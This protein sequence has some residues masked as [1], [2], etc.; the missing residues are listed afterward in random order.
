MKQSKAKIVGIIVLVVAIL[1]A[2]TGIYF[3]GILQSWGSGDEQFLVETEHY[4]IEAKIDGK[5][6]STEELD[7]W[8]IDRIRKVE[9]TLD[10]DAMEETNAQVMLAVLTEEKLAMSYDEMVGKLESKLDLCDFMT[11]VIVSLSNDKTKCCIT[12]VTVEGLDL[13]IFLAEFDRLQSENSD[14]NLAVNLSVAPDH[15]YLG[16][17][18]DGR[19]EVIET[20][21]S[22]FFSS[23]F[24]ITY[25]DEEGLDSVRD[26]ENYEY[27]TAGVAKLSN[28]VIEGGVRHQFAGTENGFKAQLLVEFPTFTPDSIV[29][30]HQ[31]HLACEFSNWVSW[32]AENCQ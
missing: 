31:M 1:L 32:I 15:Y 8:V 24:F 20:C 28:G 11:E 16:V 22:N 2:G 10:L 27:Q 9:K 14:E 12:E 18:D 5:Y 19:L 30:N 4:T 25:G 13:D 29:K 26:V 21:G 3:S 23:Q 7:D 6:I 17:T